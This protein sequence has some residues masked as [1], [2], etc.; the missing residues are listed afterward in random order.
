[1]FSPTTFLSFELFSVSHIAMIALFV[2]IFLFA[3]FFLRKTL[4]PS[5]DRSIRIILAAVLILSEVTYQFWSVSVGIWDAKYFIPIQ[6]C[7]FSTFFGLFL[8]FKKNRYVFFFFFY[9]A[10]FPPVFAILT[11]DL[12]YDFPHYFYWKFFFQHIAIPVTAIYI[13]FRDQWEL[14][15][16]SIFFA[17]IMLNM[18]AIPIGLVNANIGSNYFFLAGPPVSDTALS[19]FSDSW[20]YILQLE[21]VALF[22]FFLTFFIGRLL[23]RLKKNG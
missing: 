7:S 16:K 21:A 2:I 6:L 15:V 5:T 14:T 22:F 23:L 8:L 4:S 9:V 10:F 17:F 3:V 19:L 1:M 11:P 12:A 20:V 18:A 13:L